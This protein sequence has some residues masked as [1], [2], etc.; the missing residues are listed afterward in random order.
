MEAAS[1]RISTASLNSHVQ[2]KCQICISVLCFQAHYT[3]VGRKRMDGVAEGIQQG[4]RALISVWLQGH[5]VENAQQ[6][7]GGGASARSVW[8][9]AVGWGL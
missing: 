2:I 4:T 8:K 9:A 6:A 3:G 7:G 1:G 5:T